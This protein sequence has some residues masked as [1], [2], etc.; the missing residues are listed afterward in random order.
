M[1]EGKKR[2]RGPRRRTRRRRLV[3]ERKR[4]MR[5]QDDHTADMKLPRMI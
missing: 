5:E 1:M 4:K 2:T 3:S